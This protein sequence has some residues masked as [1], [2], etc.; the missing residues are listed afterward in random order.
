[1]EVPVEVSGADL[2]R[3]M[4]R[5]FSQSEL[6]L[7]RLRA[8]I[9]SA[10]PSLVTI[11]D[12]APSLKGREALA[13]CGLT[14]YEILQISATA[15]DGYFGQAPRDGAFMLMIKDAAGVR[16]TAI[17]TRRRAL[18]E[19][20]DLDLLNTLAVGW[21][22]HEQGHVDDFE[23]GINLV[24]DRPID[25]MAA[26]LYA[27]HFACRRLAQLGL[28]ACMGLYLNGVKAHFGSSVKSIRDSAGS[29]MASSEFPGYCAVAGLYQEL[30]MQ[31]PDEPKP[32]DL[33]ACTYRESTRKRTK[34][35]K[36]CGRPRRR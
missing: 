14:Q 16:R 3:M 12:V 24:P 21:L 5:E 28:S 17:F 22:L 13:A 35:R 20:Q 15:D 30:L 34:D 23:Q 18:D 1:V 25:F 32:T 26:E 2:V 8:E 10:H 7:S 19:D 36:R 11:A 31:R 9:M 4:R 27:H 33:R 6:V 29:F